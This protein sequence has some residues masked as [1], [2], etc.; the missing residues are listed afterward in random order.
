MNWGQLGK[1]ISEMTAAEQ[2]QPAT[3]VDSFD[4]P[5][6]YRDLD[7]IRATEDIITEGDKNVVRVR[8]DFTGT[9]DGKVYGVEEYLVET[10]GIDEKD[11]K[12]AIGKALK[13]SED[14]QYDDPRID[15]T[16]SAEIIEH[17]TESCIA[18]RKGELML[19]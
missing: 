6:A 16:R 2:A 3:F 13:L 18:V 1:R 8:V 9:D 11:D 14:S 10:D 19:R 7:L 15:H 17:F 5:E 4:D 12:K